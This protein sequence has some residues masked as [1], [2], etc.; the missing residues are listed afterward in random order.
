MGGAGFLQK[1]GWFGEVMGSVG[2]Q[3]V[4]D[5]AVDPLDV[6]KRQR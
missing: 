2:Q 1:T 5:F 4:E 6:Y 3:L